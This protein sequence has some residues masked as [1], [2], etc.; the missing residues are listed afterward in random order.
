MGTSPLYY[1]VI[2]GAC[3]VLPARWCEAVM[4]W[5]ADRWM[6]WARPDRA[7]VRANLE[8]VLGPGA[9]VSA[10][11]VREV[12][13]NFARYLCEFFSAHHAH[14]TTVVL[15]H[16]ERL[17]QAAAAGRGVIIM[18]A[19]LGNWEIGGMILS[20]LGYTISAVVLPHVNRRVDRLFNA[21]RR[22]CGLGA[23]PLGPRA[24]HAA[25]G[26]LRRGE[27][28]AVLGDREFGHNGML[29]SFCGHQ[30]TM[31]RGP[32][33]LSVRTGA[34][35]VPTFLTREG[36]RQFRLAFE[37]PCWPSPTAAHQEEIERLTAASTAA[38]ER[39]VR[40]CPTQWV[41]FQPCNAPV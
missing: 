41:M 37:E 17:Q 16:P 23:I 1:R 2:Q 35:L 36:P 10:E 3:A 34:P 20:R 24:A 9:S 8:L 39:S 21:Q 40:Q 27:L 13:R 30:V 29:V 14:Q 11:M 25:M 5:L 19:H 31:P 4:V 28:L 18:S 33:L 7:A 32:A 26:Q 6:W 38:I 15:Q 22:R 12:F